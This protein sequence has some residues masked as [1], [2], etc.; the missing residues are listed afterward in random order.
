MADRWTPKRA[1]ICNTSLIKEKNPIQKTSIWKFPHVKI[2]FKV[3]NE[4]LFTQVQYCNNIRKGFYFIYSLFIS[5]FRSF[6]LYSI[7]LLTL[8]F[9]SWFLPS[10]RFFHL[11]HY[12]I[13]F[14]VFMR[15][16]AFLLSFSYVESSKFFFNK[17]L[18]ESNVSKIYYFT[19][20]LTYFTECTLLLPQSSSSQL[21]GPDFI[22]WLIDPW[23]I[24]WHV[25][26]LTF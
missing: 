6:Y 3:K 25:T 12:A 18:C 21:V 24:D 14:G 16:I 19:G 7:Q 26:A 20:K 2:L 13:H 22:C 4:I 11:F 15:Q 5:V 8:C 23:N 10:L 17:K 1:S 9:P